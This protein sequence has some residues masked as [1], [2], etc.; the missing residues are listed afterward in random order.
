MHC[1]FPITGT[2][3]YREPLSFLS[4]LFLSEGPRFEPRS[5][6]PALTTLPHAHLTSSHSYIGISNI[7]PPPPS[8]S[9]AKFSK[10]LQKINQKMGRIRHNALHFNICHKVPVCI[11][12]CQPLVIR[13]IGLYQ[14]I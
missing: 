11:S 1:D 4:S 7:P 10:V 3:L 12:A 5:P 2:Y 6:N 9:Y 14:L 13:I 8:T